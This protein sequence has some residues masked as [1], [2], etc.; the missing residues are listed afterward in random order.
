MEAFKYDESVRSKA[1]AYIEAEGLTRADFAAKVSDKFSGTRIT[2]YLNLN[3]EGRTPEPDMPKVEQAIRAFLRHVGRTTKI[4]ENLF[5]NSVSGDVANVL[6]QIRRTGDVGLIHSNGGLGKTSG[7]V[8]FCNDN[9]NTLM[10]T[11]KQYA[12][13]AAAFE[14]MLFH[15]Y[16]ENSQAKYPGN[17]KRMLWLEQELRGTERMIIVDDAELM[18]ISGFRSAFGLHDATGIPIAFVGNSEVIDAIR[19]RDSSGKMISRIG[20]L[21]LAK[22]KDDSEATARNLIR[23]FAPASGDELVEAVQDVVTRFGHCRRAR[24]QLSLAAFIYEGMP[25]KDWTAAFA[26]ANEKLIPIITTKK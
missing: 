22:M 26:S 23:Q 15:A 3:K 21:H 16:L 4:R 10:I 11:I 5:D 24:K 8:L 14:G 25:R 1:E 13:G 9:P 18:D 6:R 2:K 12:C 20:I 19:K 17:I 7:C